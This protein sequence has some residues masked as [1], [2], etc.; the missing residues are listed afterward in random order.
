[1]VSRYFFVLATTCFATSAIAAED[2]SPEWNSTTLTGD[3]GG[4]RTNLYNKGVDLEFTHKS[5]FMSNT[6]GGLKRGTVWMGHTE[7]RIKLN[8]EKLAG[9]DATTAYIH[10]HSDTGSKFQRD[11]AGAFVG[12]DNIETGV[13][14][15]QLFHAWIQK[16][17]FADSLSVLA[18]LYPIDSE[19]YATDTSGVFIQP[20]YGMANDLAQPIIGGASQA[21]AIFPTGALALRVKYL[22]P[23]KGF[24]AQYAL[25]DGIP[26]DPKN[27][28][29]THIQLNK[30]DGTLSI[31]EFGLTPQEGSEPPFKTAQPSELIE[32]ESKVHEES[33]S[34]NKT[35]IGFWRYSA[36]FD[37]PV[38]IGVRRP[39]QGVYFLA[40]R[41]LIIK[42]NHPAQGLS[43]FVRFGT[44]SRDIHQA[45]WTGSVGLRYHG[46]FEDRDDDIAGIAFTYNHTS[47]KFRQLN[48]GAA[49]NQS[50]VEAT[51]RAQIKPW[52]ALQPTLQF[53]ANPNMK[54]D[55]AGNPTLKNVWIVGARAEINL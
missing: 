34:F 33:E 10:F 43:G 37:D 28:R 23:S 50:Q 46:L 41:T 39:S 29:S 27:L 30:G 5:D 26:G 36:Q 14:T 3:W 38:D 44:A 19:F 21:P 22:S 11:Y 4:G 8:M 52:F 15:A 49:S 51:Y 47:D 7:A 6:S 1:M 55:L 9:W 16:S 45:D 31:A 54:L 17:F 42:K 40:E 25:V 35:A 32:P 53:V 12:V 24:Y 20:P 18:G 2:K 48:A 13:N